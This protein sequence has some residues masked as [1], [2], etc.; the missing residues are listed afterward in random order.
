MRR[1]LAPLCAA[2]IL[3]VAGSESFGPAGRDT[4]LAGPN[5]AT[6]AT[7]IT[8]DKDIGTLNE[9]NVDTIAKGFNPANPHLGDAIVATFFWTGA[10][11]ITSVSDFQSDAAHTPVGN[12]FH[13]VEQVSA[14]GISMATYVATNVQGFPDPNPDPTIV[15][16]VRAVMSQPVADGGVQL[17]AYSGVA[18][19]F[20]DALGGHSSGSGA[21]S[22]ATVSD[23]GSIPIN[24]GALAYAVTMA[25]GIVG[26]N[27]PPNYLRF[28]DGTMSDNSMVAEGDY[29]VASATGTTDPQWT[30]GGFNSP[31]TWPH[32]IT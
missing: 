2:T 25:N 10:A 1:S 7:G 8:F 9:Q 24:A 30:W 16:A 5:A 12:T 17:S 29:M 14:G 28:P 27:P 13:L 21:S 19:V 20:T 31:A 15:Y 32:V 18:P 6:A 26:R 11:T 22:S 23:A 3:S 4:R